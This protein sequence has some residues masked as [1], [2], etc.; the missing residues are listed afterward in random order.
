MNSFS[1]AFYRSTGGENRFFYGY[2]KCAGL[3]D[4]C[5]D[6]SCFRYN[7]NIITFRTLKDFD[8]I[9]ILRHNHIRK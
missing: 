7:V 8:I 5:D 1:D 9:G 6:L 3:Y 2:L 4:K